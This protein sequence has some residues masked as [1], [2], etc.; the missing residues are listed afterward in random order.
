MMD[1]S[2]IDYQQS[3]AQYGNP[4]KLYHFIQRLQ[5]NKPSNII[6]CGGSITLEGYSLTVVTF[7][8]NRV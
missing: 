6:V 8:K 1:I 3:S 7:L 5:N 4:M 2:F